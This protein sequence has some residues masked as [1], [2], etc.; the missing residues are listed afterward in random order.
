M[1]GRLPPSQAGHREP[2]QSV[3]AHERGGGTISLNT[4]S[5]SPATAAVSSSAAAIGY[6]RDRDSGHLV[7]GGKRQVRGRAVAEVAALSSPGLLLAS[8]IRSATFLPAASGSPPA[9]A[10]SRR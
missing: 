10:S 1:S 8:A 2:V 5:T 7:E 6:V 9:R 3:V 4:S